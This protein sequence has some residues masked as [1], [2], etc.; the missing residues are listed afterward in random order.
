MEQCCPIVLFLLIELLLLQLLI[1]SSNSHLL[2]IVD[3][4]PGR[5]DTQVYIIDVDRHEQHELLTDGDLESF[6]RSFLP[7]STLDSGEPRLV[8]S[9]RHVL[10]GFAARLTPGELET[11]K[12]KPGFLYAQ[13]DRHYPL[14]TTYTPKYLGV[15]SDN[16]WGSTIMGQGLIIGIIDTG[17]KACHP[18]FKDTDMAPPP[19]KWKGSCSYSGFHCNNKIIGVKAFR[20]GFN[21]S[22]EDTDGH[23]THVASIAAGNF[24]KDANVLGMAKGGPASGMAPLAHLSIY[25]VC[26]PGCAESDTY[27][28]IDQAIKDGVDIIS[29]SITGGKNY[30]FYKDSISRG[31]LAAIQHGI[32]PVSIAGNDGPDAGTLSHSAPFKDALLNVQKHSGELVRKR[33]S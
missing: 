28:A 10:N 14:A 1:Q 3:E 27:A 12:S 20:G 5:H 6:H 15:T 33:A 18:S 11:V 16:V 13:C 7:N 21:P 31:S 8:Y 25:K 9:Y 4:V 22:P 2:P 23:G 26:F 19:L 32:V 29:M 17:I 24:V 30:K